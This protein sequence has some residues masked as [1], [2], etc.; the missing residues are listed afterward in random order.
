M[1]I[2]MCAITIPK[3]FQYYCAEYFYFS[4]NRNMLQIIIN[5]IKHVALYF[6]IWQ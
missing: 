4:K 6:G 3:N 5:M 2:I 1:Y